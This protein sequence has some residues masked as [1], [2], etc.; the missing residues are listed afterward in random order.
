LEK[1][2]YIPLFNALQ[3]GAS[4]Y[5]CVKSFRN[6]TPEMEQAESER[7]GQNIAVKRKDSGVGIKDVDHETS[8]GNPIDNKRPATKGEYDA[9]VSI[10]RE[11]LPK[12]SDLKGLIEVDLTGDNPHI[13]IDCNAGEILESCNEEPSVKIRMR[14]E[15]VV[16]LKEGLMDARYAHHFNRISSAGNLL[17]GL[18]FA[19]LLSP[20]Q[21]LSPPDLS[22][23]KRLPEP[24]TDLQ[25]VKRDLKEFGYG[26]VKDALSPEQLAALQKRL[27][28][29]AEGEAK[30]GVAFYDGGPEKP[31]QRIW[32]LPNKGQEFL[33]LLEHPLVEEFMPE[34][35]GDGYHLSSY[36]ANV[37]SKMNWKAVQI[38]DK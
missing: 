8:F 23:Y 38:T 3:A 34:S 22:S 10:L 19:D 20:V 32:A 24:T 29:Q 16:H 1:E 37:G 26:F 7:D 36:T 11:K 28:N 5:N 13:F 14:P 4:E 9:A 27:K 30:A 12:L 31:N 18:K 17:L 2:S 33:D 35:L 6:S 21:P 25:Q 15:T